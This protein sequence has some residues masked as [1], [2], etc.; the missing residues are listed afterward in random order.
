MSFSSR[1]Q[2]GFLAFKQ[3]FN[4][5][6]RPR[7]R[8]AHSLTSEATDLLRLLILATVLLSF[9]ASALSQGTP[10]VASARDAIERGR[11]EI[12]VEDLMELSGGGKTNPEALTFLATAR[13]YRDR[14]FYDSFKEFGGAFAAGGGASFV[15]AHSHEALSD[16]EVVNV[17]RG[18]LHLR[19]GTVEFE[20][21]ESGHSFRVASADIEE[22]EPNKLSKSLFHVRTG[23]K[24]W[25]FRPRT[26]TKDESQLVSLVFNKFVRSNADRGDR[27]GRSQ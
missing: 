8:H 12:A 11:Y 3:T 4:D 20:S 24:V 7:E 23:G 13:M 25:N 6:C 16:A 10:T 9:A 15:V 19:L 1:R 22:I 17:C 18:W 21:S 14:R 26:A 5:R 27:N 2:F